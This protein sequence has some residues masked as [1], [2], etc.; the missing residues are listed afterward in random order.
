MGD[1]NSINFEWFFKY[2]GLLI[3][4]G[5]ILIL[6]AIVVY[7]IGK[8]KESKMDDTNYKID[9][10]NTVDNT[11]KE[12]VVTPLINPTVNSDVSSVTSTEN[13]VI[14]E[15]K[16]EQPV[17]T[18][19]FEP[20]VTP[21]EVKNDME[22]VLPTVN[23]E[24]NQATPEPVVNES[25]AVVPIITP[26]EP[27]TITP[28]VPKETK[29]EEKVEIPAVQPEVPKVENVVA[30]EVKPVEINVTPTP[31]V[32][33]VTQEEVAPIEIGVPTVN[34]EVKME[35]VVAVNPVTPIVEAEVPQHVE[36]QST[37][38]NEPVVENVQKTVS[39]STTEDVIEEI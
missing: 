30:E 37:T 18:S 24:T 8:G 39:Q 27:V 1:G 15:T 23:V 9:V 12:N 4:L 34:D 25:P 21:V 26:I 7:F 33:T 2:P 29:T 3:T 17:V 20:V 16:V 6:I 38:L 13:P 31:V 10:D 22:N 35:P 14:T 19:A 11:Q 28:V 32:Q 36:V 5:V